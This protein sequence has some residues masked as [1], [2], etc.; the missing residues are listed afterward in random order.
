[1]TKKFVE[2]SETIRTEA[3]KALQQGETTA[4]NWVDQ[5]NTVCDYY[6]EEHNPYKEQSSEGAIAKNDKYIIF[7]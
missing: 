6:N 7:S 2:I 3:L 4:R 5:W 1:M